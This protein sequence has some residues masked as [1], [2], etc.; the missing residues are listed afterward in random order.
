MCES[1]IKNLVAR[2]WKT[3][4]LDLECGSHYVDEIVTVHLCGTV[5]RKPDQ[6]VAPTASLPLITILALFWEKSGICRDHALRMLREAI[7]E[8]MENGKDNTNEQIEARMKDVEKAVKAVKTDLIAKLP[9][10]KRSGRVVTKEL[11]VTVLTDEAIA[12]A[13]YEGCSCE[14]SRG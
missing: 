13:A 10:V 4:S 1:S 8:A 11:E 3:E 12:P 7:T 9:K 2:V 6:L 14:V 5:E